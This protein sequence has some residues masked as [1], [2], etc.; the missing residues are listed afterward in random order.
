MQRARTQGARQWR[1]GYEQQAG[2]HRLSRVGARLSLLFLVET[3]Q[4]IGQ[5]RYQHV[6]LWKEFEAAKHRLGS[7]SAFRWAQR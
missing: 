1:V 6:T 5:A 4:R 2:F 3:P 7:F